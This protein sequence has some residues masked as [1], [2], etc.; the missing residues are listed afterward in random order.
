MYKCSHNISLGSTLPS[1]APA[2]FHPNPEIRIHYL[3]PD[4]HEA[5]Y[6]YS[7]QGASPKTANA[8]TAGMQYLSLY[9]F[10]PG[11]GGGGG[12]GRFL[13]NILIL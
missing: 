12:L 10:L 6:E 7:H 3:N 1:S 8:Q 5:G 11:G 9:F 2:R 4:I 13:I